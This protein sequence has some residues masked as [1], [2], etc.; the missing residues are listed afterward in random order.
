MPNLKD[1]DY[2][3]MFKD[4]ATVCMTEHVCGKCWDKGCY[5]GYARECIGDAK[6][7]NTDTIQGGFEEIPLADFKGG[8]DE[9][10]ILDAIA[11]TLKQCKSCKEF[12]YEDCLVNIVRSCFES[13]AFG[14]FVGYPGNALE[15]LV[16]VQEK[17]PSAALELMDEYKG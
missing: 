8:Y 13:L 6:K 3:K 9:A 15:Y 17:Y 2:M 10:A 1:L 16:K 7:Q 11:H 4:I 5:V 12:H 14:E